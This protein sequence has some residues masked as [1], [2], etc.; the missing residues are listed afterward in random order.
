MQG[1][2]LLGVTAF[3]ISSVINP[4]YFVGCASSESEYQYGA[5]EMAE[6]VLAANGSYELQIDGVEHRLD[7]DVAP[8]RVAAEQAHLSGPFALSAHAC[9]NRK[10]VATAAAC[11]DSSTMDVT[12]HITLLRASDGE[13]FEE[14]ARHIPVAG[15]LYVFSRVLSSGSLELSFDGGRLQLTSPD[16]DSFSLQAGS[17]LRALT[18]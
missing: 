14:I 9:G 7:V 5:V 3:G 11:V 13:R 8:A 4:G 18:D 10:L 2:F 12:G 6:L 15:A 1:R 16:A 17:D